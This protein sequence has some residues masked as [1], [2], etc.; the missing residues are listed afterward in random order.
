MGACDNDFIELYS[1]VHASHIGL[2]PVGNASDHWESSSK[3]DSHTACLAPPCLH[4]R[5]QYS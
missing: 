1:S 5:L 3:E 2:V 4:L